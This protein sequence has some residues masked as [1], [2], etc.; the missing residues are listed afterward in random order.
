MGK[1]GILL[2]K[3]DDIDAV[4][5]MV[6]GRLSQWAKLEGK[7]DRLLDRETRR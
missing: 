3:V 5:K 2:R 7:A 4:R 6:K 1:N